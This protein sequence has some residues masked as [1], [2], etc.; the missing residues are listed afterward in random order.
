MSGL[1]PCRQLRPS[2]RREDILMLQA[3]TIKARHKS[4]Y[5]AAALKKSKLIS[6]LTVLIKALFRGSLVKSLPHIVKISSAHF[7]SRCLMVREQLHG[8]HS[9]GGSPLSKLLAS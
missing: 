4:L 9:G 3:I 5:S 8:K 2:S 1:T 7:M 6:A